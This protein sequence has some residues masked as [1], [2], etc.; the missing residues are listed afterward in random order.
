MNQPNHDDCD[1][2]EYL[3]S[4]IINYSQRV[5]FENWKRSLKLAQKNIFVNMV[6]TKFQKMFIDYKL[7]LC[8]SF[9]Q[10]FLRMMEPYVV[11]MSYKSYCK[12]IL[13]KNNLLK[14]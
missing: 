9:P 6:K 4:K 10:N 11:N 3:Y 12:L 1:T 14:E 13:F 8:S 2:A 7:I 5:G